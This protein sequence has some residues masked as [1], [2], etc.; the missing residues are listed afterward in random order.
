MKKKIKISL[1]LSLAIIFGCF[2][3]V[4]AAS[5][6]NNKAKKIT[7]IKK[8]IRLFNSAAANNSSTGNEEKDQYTKLLMHMDDDQFKDECG[9]KVT[10]QDVNL[11]TTNKKFGNG[12]AGFNGASSCLTIPASTEWDLSNKNFTLECWIKLSKNSNKSS[13]VGCGGISGKSLFS[14]SFYKPANCNCVSWYCTTGTGMGTYMLSQDFS[15]INDE[16]FHHYEVDRQGSDFY[17]FLDGKL[18]SNVNNPLSI[19]SDNQPVIIG[20]QLG[21][22]EYFQGNIDELR[23]SVGIARHTPASG[24]SLNKATDILTL[25]DDTKGTDTL[26]AEV[27]PEN[28]TSKTVKWKSSDPN[29][30]YVDEVTGKITAT[31]KGTATITAIT[32]DGTNL[33]ESCIVTVMDSVT[34]TPTPTPTSNPTDSSDKSVLNITMTNGQVKQYNVTMDTVNKFISWYRLRSAGSGDPF[35]EFDI[36]QTSSPNIIKTDYVI[37]NKISSFE[38]DDYTK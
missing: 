25:G 31:G 26:T 27:T 2:S 17:F 1:I 19:K 10:K 15:T 4:F 7:D 35:Y 30:V 13:I 24:I 32:T 36:T 22:N 16:L 21:L 14:W 38:V 28:V 37:F 33:K 12:S 11:D 6:Q 23:L 34:P 20:N 8:S 18:V 3:N 9:H 29:I 5:N